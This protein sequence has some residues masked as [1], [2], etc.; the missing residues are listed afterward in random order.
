MTK[1]KSKDGLK[2]ATYTTV[3]LASEEV[4]NRIGE[5]SSEFLVAYRGVNNATGQILE[6]GHKTI[7]A[8]SNPEGAHTAQQAGFNAEIAS[9][10]RRN[11]ESI[12][13]GSNIRTPRSED[14]ELGSNHPIYDHVKTADGVIVEGSGSQMKFIAALPK[15]AHDRINKIDQQINRIA[16]ENG[17]QT[18]YQGIPLDVPTDQVDVYRD[19]CKTLAEQYREQAEGAAKAGKPDVAAQKLKE[20]EQCDELYDN[21]RDA[22]ISTEDALNYRRD[23]EKMTAKDIA[24]NSHEAGLQGAK[25][26]A[27]IGASVSLITNSYQVFQGD[28]NKSEAFLDVGLATAKAGGLGYATAAAGSAISATMKQSTKETVRGLAKTSLPSLVITTCIT[29]TGSVRQLAAGEI[30]G[31]EF[32]N[33]IGEHG[34]GLLA[35][36][37]MAAAGQI[38][39]PIPVVGAIVGSMVGYTLSSLFYNELVLSLNEAKKSRERYKKVKAECEAVRA[40]LD[41]YHKALSDVLAQHLQMKQHTTES[42]MSGLDAALESGDSNT[43]AIIINDYAR[44]MGVELE[45]ESKSELV[46]S[47]KNKQ[48]IIL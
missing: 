13:S 19:R 44:E 22:D 41:A 32:L 14:A 30:D 28:K 17:T 31:T 16:K 39:I 35:S 36:S 12:K 7:S 21:I 2:N 29:L 24:R 34:S 45:F 38:V 10:A 47:I 23:A 5:A 43:V 20:A 3:G 42:F 40:Q 26:G 25:I 8:Y 9:T 18:R 11:S 46:D 37:T 1:S 48:S 33:Q 15:D 27:V 4:V 6:R